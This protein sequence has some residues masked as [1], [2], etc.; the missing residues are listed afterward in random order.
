MSVVE[1]ITHG[2]P[3]I[4]GCILD[5]IVIIV[6]GIGSITLII[7]LIA[8][9]WIKQPSLFSFVEFWEGYT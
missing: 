7:F 1:A 8:Q 3:E 6:P 5:K 2:I 4:F 9:F